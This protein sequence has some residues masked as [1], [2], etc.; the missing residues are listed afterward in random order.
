MY[1]FTLLLEMFHDSQYTRTA[2]QMFVINLV[3]CVYFES[4]SPPFQWIPK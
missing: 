1:F 3:M 2:I 4:K